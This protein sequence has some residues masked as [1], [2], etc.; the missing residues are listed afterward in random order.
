MNDI[1]KELENA[2]AEIK[3]AIDLIYLLETNEVEPEVALK[4]L[5]IV[6][7]DLKAKVSEYPEHNSLHFADEAY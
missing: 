6:E 1:S 2:P 7:K 5:A 3:L 4:A